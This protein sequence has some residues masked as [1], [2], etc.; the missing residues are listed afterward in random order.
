MG[1]KN[2]NNNSMSL[3]KERK[4]ARKKEI[5]Q[6]KRNK[7]VGRI[8]TVCVII[9]VLAGIGS[10]VGYTI[11]R[12]A[13]KVTADSNYSKN[14]TEG[15]FI[16]GVT[17]KDYVNL[18]D[19]KNIEVPSSEVNYSDEDLAADIKE[20]VMN[21]AD[22]STETDAA[23]VDGDRV[24]VDYVGTI[25]GEEFEGG[26]TEG[27]GDDINIGSGSMID[28]FE[29]QMIGHKIGDTFTVDVTFPEDYSNDETLAGKDASFEVTINGIYIAPEFDDAYVTEHLSDVASTA[30]EYKDY[31][32]LTK[33][34]EKL[35]TWLTNYVVENS[36]I[37]D[38][39]SDYMDA[40]KSIQKYTDQSMFQYLNSYYY[41]MLN[42]YPYNTF[43]D[44]VGMSEAKYDKSLS[45]SVKTI[46]DRNL[47][48]QAILENENL[49]VSE[50]EYKAYLETQGQTSEDYDSQVEQYGKGYV[51]QM[52]I[53]I[54]A[55][56][57]LAQYITVK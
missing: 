9:A 35:N 29:Q 27:N 20:I 19:Y 38:Y 24:N 28:D 42:Y 51:M 18:C 5:A 25:D 10:L 21:D 50:E 15:G 4:L 52:M 44:Y 53:R 34:K 16:E 57:T 2:S 7:V 3:S 33:Y 26:S 12:N 6:M 54:K 22:L 49:T 37:T 30:D 40:L 55:L 13:T 31:L 45:D 41:Q 14:L 8:V 39:P 17:A 43:E 48:Y 32:K 56:D 47:I 23:I 36:T 46:A 1:E 11:Y